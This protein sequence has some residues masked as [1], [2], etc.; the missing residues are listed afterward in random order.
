MSSEILV[1]PLGRPG[2]LGWVV[3][4]HGEMYA[5]EFGWDTSFEALVARIVADYAAGHDA[6]REAAWI[7]EVD[8]ERVGCVFC[9]A[10]DERT[11]QLRILLVDPAARGRRVGGRLVDECL[12][13]ARR[14]GYTR[15]R[16]W[17]NHPLI[18]ARRIYLSRG[19]RL[20]EEEPHH[21]FGVDLTGQVYERELAPA[22]G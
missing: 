1:R 19:F 7:A 20:I 12:A 5:A 21:S 2:D 22:G 3:M 10:A 9:V 11:A 8:G 18:A 6:A 16:L 15:M 14:A 17:T 13:F 4:A